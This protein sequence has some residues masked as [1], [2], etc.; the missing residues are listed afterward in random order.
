VSEPDR[1]APSGPAFDTL[2]R[3]ESARVVGALVRRFGDLDLAE[4]CFQEACL[5]ALVTWP[6]DGV[7][8]RPGAWLTTVARNR[9]IDRLRREGQRL[10][11]EAAALDLR[12]GG[13]ASTEP[14]ADDPL[15]S[16]DAAG[17]LADDQ[18]QLILLC[19]HPALSEDAQVAL[20][21][22]AV[23]GLTTAEVAAAF[24]VPEATMAQRVVRAKKKIAGARIPFRLPEGE[25][26]RTR[27]DTA[28]HVVYLVFN[29][30]YAA[31]ANDEPVRRELC[32]EAI[33]L[34]RLLA[35]LAP[36]N[37]EATGLLGL[38]LLQ[39][40]RRDA[41]V[42][43]SGRLLPL[44]EQDRTLWDR[45]Q[46]E[47]GS[48]LVERAL[49]TGGLGPYQLQAAIAAVHAR[50]SDQADTDWAEIHAL[51]RVHEVIAPSPL[52]T[53][54]RAVALAELEG[55][56]A[57]L[58]LVEDLRASGALAGNHRLESVRAHLLTASGDRDGARAAY[59]AAAALAT[60]PAERAYL[61]GR[62]H[63]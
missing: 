34:A 16:D 26:L 44:G 46:I 18:L 13:E 1:A 9:A 25:E 37:P 19:C 21:L 63:D 24:L 40:S 48:A 51:Y 62:A 57:G 8:T 3:A 38:L 36:G 41:R 50:A 29:E 43:R 30:G 54:N 39:D 35:A 56:A 47:E 2:F 45:D 59:A 42:D 53:L 17:P 52:V 23:G 12:P 60:S 14:G 7:P 27:T 49:S 28:L 55:P 10:H 20:T 6:D 4:D 33:R 15:L 32:A 31:S 5:S 22:R 11:R 58:S 61:V